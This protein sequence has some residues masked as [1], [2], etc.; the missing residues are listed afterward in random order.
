MATI[1]HNVS[2]D[3]VLMREVMSANVRREDWTPYMLSSRLRCVQKNENYEV[4]V[5]YIY[6]YIYVY[7]FAYIGI[8]IFIHI[9]DALHVV[10]QTEVRATY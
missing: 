3:H 6:M 4:I 8:H 1:S 10:Q 9:H 7:L 5:I 2:L